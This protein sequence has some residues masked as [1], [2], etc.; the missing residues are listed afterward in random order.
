MGDSKY[1][2]ALDPLERAEAIDPRDLQVLY[3]LALCHSK[4]GHTA[5]MRKY[6]DRAYRIDNRYGPINILLGNEQLAHARFADAVAYY[7]IARQSPETA[8]VAN[9]N[10]AVAFDRMG[11]PDKV[12]EHLIS[13]SD[14]S[15]ESFDKQRWLALINQNV[16][17]LR[18]AS[19]RRT[20]W[21]SRAGLIAFSTITLLSAWGLW[22]TIRR[23]K[24]S[25]KELVTQLVPTVA[26]GLFALLSALLPYLL[27]KGG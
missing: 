26:S 15:A 1:A 20:L 13:V 25:T 4:L 9:W 5:E 12:L 6:A 16:Q 19:E 3:D 11:Q 23:S 21:L 17:A 7:E 8:S 18:R 22:R 27:G 2:E 14:A 24:I 10:L